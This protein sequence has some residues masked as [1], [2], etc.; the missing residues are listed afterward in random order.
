MTSPKCP[1]ASCSQSPA[2]GAPEYTQLQG[3]CHRVYAC[4][5]ETAALRTAM[6]LQDGRSWVWLGHE[7]TT[8]WPAPYEVSPTG[9]W[10]SFHSWENTGKVFILETNHDRV[11]WGDVFTI[12]D[13]TQNHTITPLD[14]DVNYIVIKLIVTKESYSNCANPRW[15]KC[16]RT[17][18]K[19][20]WF[21]TS[22]LGSCSNHK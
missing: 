1:G 21:R 6:L 15:R 10:G 3:P 16:L 5:L 20:W 11:D 17:E 12:C 7:S 2:P 22:P 14:R 19:V 8:L 18:I 9:H 4:F 13:H